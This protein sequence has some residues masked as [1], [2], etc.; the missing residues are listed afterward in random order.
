MKNFI[1][2]IFAALALFSCKSRTVVQP[3]TPV[4]KPIVNSNKAFFD[5]ISQKDDFESLKISSKINAETGQFIPTL[6][7]TFY[8]ENKQ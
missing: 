1:L 2:S 4:E 8:I 6:D 7:A 3:N 5:K